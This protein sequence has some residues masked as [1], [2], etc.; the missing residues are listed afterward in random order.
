MKIS[1]KNE[2]QNK[3]QVNK[4]K[5]ESY[6]KKSRHKNTSLGYIYIFILV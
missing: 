4:Q 1:I 5:M 2:K 3:T 6:G